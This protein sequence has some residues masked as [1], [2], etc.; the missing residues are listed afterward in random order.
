MLVVAELVRVL[1]QLTAAAFAGACLSIALVQQPVRRELSAS[2]ALDDFR[3]TIPRAERL[4][5]PLLVVSLLATVASLVLRF[6]WP[7]LVGGLLLLGVL[8]QT[9]ST[10]L[11]INRRLL[12]GAAPDHLAE[13]DA[14]LARWG[15][16]HV[17]RTVPAVLGAALLLVDRVGP[18]VR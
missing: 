10:V 14:A 5:A 4:Q 1:A 12:S 9:V 7:D 8:V 2:V 16:L 11:P 18:T 13:A 17:V 6:R 3:A 15:R